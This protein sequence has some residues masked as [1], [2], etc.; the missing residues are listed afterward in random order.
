M[1][2]PSRRRTMC[3]SPTCQLPPLG[4]LSLVTALSIEPVL[5]I[6]SPVAEYDH[7]PT[8]PDGHHI[9]DISKAVLEESGEN[10]GEGVPAAEHVSS[11]PPLREIIQGLC[12]S[13]GPALPGLFATEPAQI[14]STPPSHNGT[15]SVSYK[16]QHQLTQVASSPPKRRW[17]YAASNASSKYRILAVSHRERREQNNISTS[18]SREYILYIMCSDITWWRDDCRSQQ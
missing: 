13:T 4:A 18:Q 1:R 2:N 10:E 12:I 5:M 16:A 14:V 6:T 7:P 11:S 3:Q 9:H 15:M 17:S 8:H